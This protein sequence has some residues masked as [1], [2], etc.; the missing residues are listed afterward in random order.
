MEVL[1]RKGQN[2]GESRPSGRLVVANRFLGLVEPLL[3]R[4][5][6]TGYGTEKR[7]PQV[8]NLKGIVLRTSS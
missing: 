4:G 1:I 6:R 8:D 7:V 5:C 2:L 3:S